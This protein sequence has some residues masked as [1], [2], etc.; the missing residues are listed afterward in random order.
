MTKLESPEQIQ[1]SRHFAINDSA[2][3]SSGSL[4]SD[5][6]ESEDSDFSDYDGC[7]GQCELKISLPRMMWGALMIIM[8]GIKVLSEK[9]I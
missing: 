2:S 8:S 9:R 6:T 5:A 1:S 7:A 3:E 4:E